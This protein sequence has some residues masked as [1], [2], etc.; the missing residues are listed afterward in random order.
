MQAPKR[1]V[2]KFFAKNPEV[3]ETERFVPVFQRWIQEDFADELLIDVVDYKHV[4]EGPGIILIGYEGDTA[5]DFVYGKAGLQY[6]YKHIKAD[7]LVDALNIALKRLLVAV[8]KAEREVSLNG[9]EID[10]TKLQIAFLDRLNFPQDEATVEAVLATLTPTAQVI[11]GEEVSLLAEQ[12]DAREPLQITI[13]GDIPLALQS[14][15]T[16]S[17]TA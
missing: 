4:P 1:F 12:L 14:L 16:S 5:Y 11:F 3:V 17:I 7:T 2:V 8:E 15:T 10:T 6:T 9:L 13:Q